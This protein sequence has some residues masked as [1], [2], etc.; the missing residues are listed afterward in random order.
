M[1]YLR[2]RGLPGEEAPRLLTVASMRAPLGVIASDALRTAPEARLAAAPAPPE[3][4][5]WA[6]RALQRHTATPTRLPT[7]RARSDDS[8]V[9]KEGG[10]TVGSRWSA[11]TSK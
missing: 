11:R 5:R 1:F 6:F 8:R 2:S 4:T 9:G 3:D 10:R 7:G